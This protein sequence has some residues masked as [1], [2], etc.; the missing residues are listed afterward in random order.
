MDWLCQEFRWK[1]SYCCALTNLIHLPECDRM[2]VFPITCQVLPPLSKH[3]LCALYQMD[4]DKS[5]ESRKYSTSHAR[6]I[7]CGKSV[8]LPTF[9]Q[10]VLVWLRVFVCRLWVAVK[11]HESWR[12]ISASLP[13]G[14]KFK[15]YAHTHRRTHTLKQA[16]RNSKEYNCLWLHLD[17]R[18]HSY[19]LAI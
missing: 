3:S 15:I 18:P 7:C 17:T 5:T 4:G 2:T 12:L 9:L 8:Y 6:F 1:H 16:R 19:W 10:C 14:L 11:H 13:N